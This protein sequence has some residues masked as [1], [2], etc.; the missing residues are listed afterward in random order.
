MKALS[1]ADKA[2][3]AYPF[4]EKA[5]YMPKAMMEAHWSWLESSVEALIE[6]V[7]RLADLPDK[8]AQIFDYEPQEMEKETEAGRVEATGNDGSETRGR[9]AAAPVSA[10]AGR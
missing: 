6:G 2:R 10:I 7:N 3:A 1:A 8:F 9:G 5:G 4:L